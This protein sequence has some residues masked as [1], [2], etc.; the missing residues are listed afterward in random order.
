[1]ANIMH[2][3]LYNNAKYVS[4]TFTCSCFSRHHIKQDAKCLDHPNN[5]MMVAVEEEDVEEEEV[6]VVVNG[7]E[8]RKFAL[9]KRS[10]RARLCSR[11]FL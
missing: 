8:V 5:T 9:M 3:N 11:L 2:F 7:I 10:F 6:E 4:L 1:M